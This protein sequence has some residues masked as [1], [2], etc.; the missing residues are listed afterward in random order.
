MLSWTSRA[1]TGF[2][3][4]ISQ[5][6]RSARGLDNA[7]YPL[8][9]LLRC[10]GLSSA[11][12]FFPVKFVQLATIQG[13]VVPWPL[14][15]DCLAHKSGEMSREADWIQLLL[16][17]SVACLSLSVEMGLGVEE[18]SALL[19]GSLLN[20]TPP[21]RIPCQR[22]LTSSPGRGTWREAT[23]LARLCQRYKAAC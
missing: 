15:S 19:S 13:N 20:V 10:P 14:S 21:L 8:Q 17:H 9:V 7:D 1:A 2:R 23:A 4:R 5:D 12:P 18:A 16:D 3:A 22:S 11:E 6:P